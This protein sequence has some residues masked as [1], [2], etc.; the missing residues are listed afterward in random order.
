M[1]GTQEIRREIRVFGFQLQRCVH[2]SSAILGCFRDKF[3]FRNSENVRTVSLRDEFFPNSPIRRGFR[4]FRVFTAVATY[5]I[6]KISRF[7]VFPGTIP[8]FPEIQEFR[9]S[10]THFLHSGFSGISKSN[11]ETPVFETALRS[12]TEFRKLRGFQGG[13]R[14]I[15]GTLLHKLT[16]NFGKFRKNRKFRNLT[17][18]H[19]FFSGFSCFRVQRC[20]KSEKPETP[21]WHFW[22]CR[23]FP[24]VFSGFSGLNLE[25]GISEKRRFSTFLKKSTFQ[26]TGCPTYGPLLHEAKI[27]T[28]VKKTDTF[29]FQFCILRTMKCAEISGKKTYSWKLP[30]A[31]LLR[32]SFSLFFSCKTLLEI[33]SKKKLNLLQYYYIGYESREESM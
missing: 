12:S 19:F 6:C 25:S 1:S 20:E 27:W 14:E 17:L 16:K 7:W 10:G 32:R 22:E 24:R 31:P 26:I 2:G 4:V 30:I 28:S 9:K 11:P 29:F 5:K 3:V 33:A 8:R 15:S 23:N 13:F 18:L 21:K